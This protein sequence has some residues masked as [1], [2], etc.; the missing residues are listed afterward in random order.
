MDG[1]V[2]F[3]T[4]VVEIQRSDD[5]PALGWLVDSS[6]AGVEWGVREMGTHARSKTFARK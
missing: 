3:F 1:R 4:D 5:H 6:F 2:S